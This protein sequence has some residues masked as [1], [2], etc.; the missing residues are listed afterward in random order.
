MKRSQLKMAVDEGGTEYLQPQG[1][2]NKYG[3]SRTT[4]TNL[5]QK[6]RQN[7]K[8]AKHYLNL[9][10]NLKLINMKAFEQFLQ[11]LNGKYLRT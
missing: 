8:Y 9:S 2:A 4:V 10:H 3:I 11:E 5:V 6:F 1:I 7:P